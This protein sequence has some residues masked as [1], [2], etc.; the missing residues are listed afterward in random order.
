VGVL[1]PGLGGGQVVRVDE[2]EPLED[3]VLDLLKLGT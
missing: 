1:E 2:V 3:D